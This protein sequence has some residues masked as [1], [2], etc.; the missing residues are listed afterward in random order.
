MIVYEVAFTSQ[1]VQWSLYPERLRF[2]SNTEIA[3]GNYFPPYFATLDRNALLSGRCKE[4]IKQT[5]KWR[6]RIIMVHSKGKTLPRSYSKLPYIVICCEAK[7]CILAA[8]LFS[9]FNHLFKEE[10]IYF[11]SSFTLSLAL[12]RFCRQEYS[13]FT[14]TNWESNI[15]SLE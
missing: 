14:T 3:W 12:L 5:E 4:I 15:I 6:K 8:Q 9:S 2:T 11:I 10:N 7:I 1:P 13:V